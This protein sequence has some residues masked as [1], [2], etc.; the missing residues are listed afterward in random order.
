MFKLR[1]I[2]CWS[3]ALTSVVGIQ[4][5]AYHLLRTTDWRLG[6]RALFGDWL[7]L[8][9]YFVVA[10]V[11]GMAW[12]T[13]WR[14]KPSSRLWGLSASLLNV[15]TGFVVVLLGIRGGMP[16]SAVPGILVVPSI[17]IVGLIAFWRSYKPDPAKNTEQNSA[18][19]GDGTN[20][21][22]NSIAPY[23]I[24][25]VAY[26]TYVW[27]IEWLIKND[28]LYLESS[29]QRIVLAVLIGIVITI[30]HELGHAFSGILFGM[31]L[32]AFLA[33]PFQWRMREGRWQFQFRP[34]AVLSAGGATGLVP[35]DPNF[36]RWRELLVI[37]A[38][39]ATT[40]VTGI[41]ALCIAFYVSTDSPWQAYGIP[42]LFGVWSV[43]LG[44]M[45]LLPFRTPTGYSDGAQIYQLLSGG[46]WGDFHRIIALVGSTV[47]TA[48]R[49]R[50]YE[51]DAIRRTSLAISQGPQGLLLQ[52]FAYSHFLDQGKAVEA[53]VALKRAEAIY[54]QSASAIPVELYTI[55]VFGEAYVR[56]DAVS[57]REWWARM[58]AKKPTHFNVDYWR[59]LA[60]L[61][62]IEGNL[63]SAE[64][65]FKKSEAAADRLPGFGAYEFDRYCNSLLRDVLHE[66]HESEV[67]LAKKDS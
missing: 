56:R 35:A 19:P 18:L 2:L 17:G 31:K 25:G 16:A 48:L 36:P 20:P 54:L 46:P 59:A 3:F 66:A 45:N 40:F 32:R 1:T 24:L 60:A 4:L 51:I 27:W 15:V 62:W 5:A 21:I 61:H 22:L 57:A 64:E 63:K 43:V 49:P 9:V 37:A 44:A 39:P 53:D 58:E 38:G 10:F 47:V 11:F 26:G 67:L 14:D 12:W 8:L 28:V 30:A 23:A 6:P 29:W 65:A 52:L 33:G 13:V 55:F 7:E 41:A 34:L 42:A 50:D